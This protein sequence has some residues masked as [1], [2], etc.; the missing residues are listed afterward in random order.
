MKPPV[1]SVYRVT[2]LGGTQREI[3]TLIGDRFEP[4]IDSSVFL[5]SGRSNILAM[6]GIYVELEP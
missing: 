3:L 2:Y 1:A 5:K 6:Y 4:Q